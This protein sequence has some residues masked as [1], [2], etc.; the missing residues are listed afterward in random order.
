[1]PCQKL[2]QFL[3][4]NEIRYQLISHPTTYTA[5]LTAASSHV[6]PDILAKTVMVI[7]DGKFSMAVVPA[8]RR[9]D[10]TAL[11]SSISAQTVRLASELEFKEKFPDCDAGAMPPFGNLYGMTVYVDEAIA[12]QVEIAFNAGT[13][14]ETVRMACADFMRS[15]Q[16]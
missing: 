1:M 3:D 8:P 4:S 15:V 14:T 12:G 13:H 9:V 6:P 5:Q 16:P 10:L 2:K 11:H 7:I